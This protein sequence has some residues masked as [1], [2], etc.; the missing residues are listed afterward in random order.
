MDFFAHQDR[1]RR[2]THLLVVLFVLAVVSIVAVV[3]LVALAFLGFGS[4]PDGLGV[5]PEFS[6]TLARESLPLLIW[7]S[8]LTA[9]AIGLASLFRILTLRNGG[10]AVARGLGGVM[11]NA[12]T[13]DPQLQRLRNVVEEMS[14][15]AGVPVPQI[16][17]LEQEDGIN[18]FAAGYSPA[19]AAIAVTRGALRTLSRSELQGVVAHEF[20]HILNGDMRLNIRLIGILFGILVLAIIG[21]LMLS[22]R[23][24]RASKHTAAIAMIGLALVATGYIGLLFGRLIRASVSRQREFLADASAIQFTREPEGIAGALKKIGSAQA[25]SALAADSEE[26]GHM[27]FAAG[28]TRRLLATHPPIADRIRAIEPGFDP[29]ELER[30]RA[31]PTPAAS[32][33]GLVASMAEPGPAAEGRPSA[34]SLD[35]DCIVEAI[36][37]PNRARIQVAARLNRAIPEPLARAARSTEWVMTVVCYL[38]IDPDPEIRER[39]LLMVAETLGSEHERQ[40]GTLLSAVP[41]L[42]ADLRIPL[43]EIAFPTLRRRPQ[44]ELTRLMALLDRLIHADGQIDVFEYVLAR[45]LAQQI[46]DT[47]TPSD[48]HSAGTARLSDRENEVRDL[49]IILAVHG[50]PDQRTA[51]T[52]FA[53]GLASLGMRRR[54]LAPIGPKDW[55]ERLDRALDRLDR[56]R[57]DDKQRLLRALIATLQHAGIN[58][59]EIELLR[60]VV[61]ALHVPMPVL[62]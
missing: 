18:A 21:R 44:T 25:G 32:E 15:A 54:E 39:Q 55:P 40:V 2:R 7:V 28:L 22:V 58:R 4:D 12:D 61:A 46:Q 43:L 9:G 62:D 37:R 48:A 33:A 41:S 5:S 27:L 3:D 42:A 49:L 52:S 31:M 53:A 59:T 57:M 1:A 47:I 34:S 23:H 38:L 20:S 35:A 13:T 45:L 19:D 60:A 8:V 6:W 11:V 10:G 26:I 56:L 51:R 24:G 17:V 29:A 14:I 36:G 16:Y 50:N 30:M